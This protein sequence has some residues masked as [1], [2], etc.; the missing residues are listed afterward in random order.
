VPLRIQVR[1]LLEIVR[2]LVDLFHLLDE[3]KPIA[4]KNA[5]VFPTLG[6]S[7]VSLASPKRRISFCC[8]G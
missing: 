5:V 8:E 7:G 2:Q 4:S 1:E 6:I 3:A